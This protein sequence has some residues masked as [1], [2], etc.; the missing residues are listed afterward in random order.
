MPPAPPLP[1]VMYS[2]HQV[3]EYV[4]LHHDTIARHARS[5][6]LPFRKIGGRWMMSG[7]DLLHILSGGP[8]DRSVWGEPE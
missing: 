8:P 1:H 3:A 2:I 5:G 7:R 4:A 6:V